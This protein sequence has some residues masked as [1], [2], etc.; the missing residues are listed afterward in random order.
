MNGTFRDWPSKVVVEG[1][2][3]DTNTYIG[4]SPLAGALLEQ[5]IWVVERIDEDGANVFADVCL[6]GE[7]DPEPCAAMNDPAN[8]DYTERGPEGS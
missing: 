3:P 7:A 2:D 8:L 1:E 5:A 6:T 4:Y